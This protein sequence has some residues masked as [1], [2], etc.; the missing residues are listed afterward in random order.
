MV[1]QLRLGLDVVRSNVPGP[2]FVKQRIGAGI[3]LLDDFGPPN[4]RAKIKLN[5]L[6]VMSGGNCV[7]GQ[8]YGDYH[9][10]CYMLGIDPSREAARR[11]F[12][13][14]DTPLQ[15]MEFAALTRGWKLALERQLDHQ[16]SIK[17]AA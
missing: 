3:R 13:A 1:H 10:G 9:K 2:I 12:N 17:L 15:G 8:I 6:D 5:K 7:L 16:A 11:G 4:W 14:P